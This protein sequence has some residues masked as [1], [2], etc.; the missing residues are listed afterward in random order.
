MKLFSLLQPFLLAV[1]KKP[2]H[3]FVDGN[4][5]IAH[6]RT[7]T[8]RDTLIETLRGVEGAEEIILVFDGRPGEKTDISVDNCLRTVSLGEG[9]STDDFIQEEIQKFWVDPT[10]RRKHRV[11]LVSADRELRKHA[12]AFKPIVKTV[13]NPVT[14][15]RRYLPRML[16]IKKRSA[17]TSE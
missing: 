17:D 14:F 3:W 1:G 15:F 12:L 11:N 8:N 2:T 16:G 7:T 13:I 6:S 10:T 5:L 9:L 4:N